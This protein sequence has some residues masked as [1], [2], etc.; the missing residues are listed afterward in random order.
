MNSNLA[1]IRERGLN[2]LFKELGTIGAINFLRQFENSAGNYTEDREALLN[3][4]TI[5]DIAERIRRRN[6]R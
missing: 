1:E 5:D 4:I 3:G 6:A 2:A